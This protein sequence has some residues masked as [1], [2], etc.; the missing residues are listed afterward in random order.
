[1]YDS[2][3]NIRNFLYNVSVADDDGGSLYLTISMVNKSFFLIWPTLQ[4]FIQ[5]TYS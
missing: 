4:H 5:K 1:M 3:M 2:L